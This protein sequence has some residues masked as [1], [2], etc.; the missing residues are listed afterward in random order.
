[1]KIAIVG[2]ISF[3]KEMRNV[4]DQ[5]VKMDHEVSIPPSAELNQTKEYWGEIKTK[6]LEEFVKVG[7]E[8]NLKYFEKIKSSDAI[9][10]MNFD[11]NGI[12]NYIGA[13]TF[14]EMTVAFENN[15]KIFL[16]NN[17]P[18]KFFGE[19]EISYMNPVAINSDLTKIK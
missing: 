6:D 18:K 19:E 1:M 15:K 3:I 2:S 14:M 7:R 11:K 17:L 9:L 16:L 4:R 10:V 12:K 8:R 5:L 13:N